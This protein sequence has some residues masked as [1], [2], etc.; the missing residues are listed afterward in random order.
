MTPHAR[1]DSIGTAFML[2]VSSD[3]TSL[4]LASGSCRITAAAGGMSVQCVPGNR[5]D[6]TSTV[7]QGPLDK[8][9]VNAITGMRF[10]GETG[11]EN[12]S[13]QQQTAQIK[14]EEEQAPV[15]DNEPQKGRSDKSPQKKVLKEMKSET[16]IIRNTMRKDKASSQDNAREMRQLRNRNRGR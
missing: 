10:P 3:M 7:T 9:T 8:N 15:Q 12:S 14:K 6:V 4:Y 1:I 5:Y 2:S 11:L 13:G 16:R